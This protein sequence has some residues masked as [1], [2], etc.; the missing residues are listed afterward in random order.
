MAWLWCLA[1]W[2][3]NYPGER[4]PGA[5]RMLFSTQALLVALKLDGIGAYSWNVTFILSWLWLGSLFL[6]G[7]VVSLVGAAL[8]QQRVV[9]AARTAAQHL[10]KVGAAVCL[11]Q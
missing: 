11:L 8:L 6:F 4:H 7:C 1:D 2:G 9:K 5:M 3:L 10:G